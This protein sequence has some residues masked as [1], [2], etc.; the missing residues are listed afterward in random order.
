MHPC[1]IGT[2]VGVWFLDGTPVRV[3]V[4]GTRFRVDGEPRELDL[5][6]ET[7]WRIRV[8]H[9]SGSREVLELREE[10]GG[11]VLAGMRADAVGAVRR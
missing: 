4:G 10:G 3:V 6:G 11:W 8:R 5:D 7:R 1:F 2:P 9:D